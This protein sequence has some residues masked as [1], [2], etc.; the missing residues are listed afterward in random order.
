MVRSI[1]SKS[2]SGELAA[3]NLFA[4]RVECARVSR[5]G[6][7][8]PVVEFCS[9]HP[10]EADTLQHLRRELHLKRFRCSTLLPAPQYQL[11]LL[12]APNV[13]DAE[14]KSAVRWKLKDFLEYPVDSAT[15]DVVQVPVDA[16]APT[17]GRAGIRRNLYH[18]N[19]RRFD[20]ILEKVLQFPAHRRLHFRVRHVGRVQQLQLVLRCR[21]QRRAA[22]ALEVKFATQALQRFGLVAPGRARGTELHDRTLRSVAAHPGDLEVACAKV[23]GSEFAGF[24]FGEN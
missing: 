5:N 10:Y 4:G 6:A 7:E 8:R 15:V 22:K 24:A 19:G 1:F 21:Q 17:R 12:D 3:V 20:W 16:G 11:Q 14:L 23:H 9:G 18:V 2:E 13:P